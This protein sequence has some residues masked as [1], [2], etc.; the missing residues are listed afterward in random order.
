MT[1]KT[2]ISV[3]YFD[4]RLVFVVVVIKN[5]EGENALAICIFLISHF[6]RGVVHMV[7]VMVKM[8][9]VKNMFHL[10]KLRKV[11]YT[12]TRSIFAHTK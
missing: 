9:G 8:Q 3:L 10:A 4:G 2:N 12:C 5:L 7:S 6:C 11:D 1:Q